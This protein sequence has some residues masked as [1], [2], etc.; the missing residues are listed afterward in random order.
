MLIKALAKKTDVSNIRLIPKTMECYTAIITDKFRFIGEF[1]FK[2]S[3]GSYTLNNL[4]LNL[5]KLRKLLSYNKLFSDSYQ[6]LSSPLS[7]LVEDLFDKGK[8]V[9]NFNAVKTFI[10]AEHGG[11]PVKFRLLMR[12][13]FFPFSYMNSFERFEETCLPTQQQFFDELTETPCS[14]EDYGH[15]Q[16]VWRTFGLR[17][18][19][20]LCDLYVKS[21]VLLLSDVFEKYRSSTI[22]DHG[23]DPIHYFTCPGEFSD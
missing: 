7:K 22:S 5:L 3:L 2:I 13:G 10:D 11:D 4:P 17:T 9:N 8:G 16:N 1:N 20:D 14:D 12:K 18:M 23:L 19:G 6:H 15:V 21:D